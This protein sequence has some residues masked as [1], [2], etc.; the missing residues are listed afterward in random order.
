MK[1]ATVLLLLTITLPLLVGCGGR[2][3]KVVVALRETGM[4]GPFPIESVERG[5]V[6]RGPLSYSGPVYKVVVTYQ[7]TE[8]LVYLPVERVAFDPEGGGEAYLEVVWRE[9]LNPRW[10]E[11]AEEEGW[12][13][14]LL[15][16]YARSYCIRGLSHGQLPFSA[17]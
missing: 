7:N 6:S 3:G 9:D 11:D 10:V 2:E 16:G 12:V 1:K 5:D 13:S 15:Q 17:Y 8:Y 4:E 14:T